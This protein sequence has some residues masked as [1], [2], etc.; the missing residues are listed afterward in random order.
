[1]DYSYITQIMK[2]SFRFMDDYFMD[3]QHTMAIAL[4]L[5]FSKKKISKIN[6]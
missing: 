4:L 2:E 6:P 3:F 1:M 5:G